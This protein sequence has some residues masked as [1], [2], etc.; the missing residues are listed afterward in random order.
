MGDTRCVTRAELNGQI[1][2]LINQVKEVRGEVD[3]VSKIIREQNSQFVE[4]LN[5]EIDKREEDVENIR[6]TLEDHSN[7]D[8]RDKV[9]VWRKFTYI[10][11]SAVGAA[12][13]TLLG[14]FLETLTRH[15]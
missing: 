6:Q 3:E 9:G 13:L 4:L 14:V 1:L 15:H 5:R 8:T 11:L 7:W 10:A 12:G 2:L